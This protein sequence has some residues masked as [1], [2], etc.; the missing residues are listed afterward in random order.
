MCVCVCVCLRGS[1]GYPK[2]S[3][4]QVCKRLET[5]G[6]RTQLLPGL[7]TPRADWLRAATW[8]EA[9][10]EGLARPGVPERQPGSLQGSWEGPGVNGAEPVAPQTN[11]QKPHWIS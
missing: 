10:R 4:N 3:N 8:R 6:A 11:R 7:R 9:R 1:V 2:S 5:C